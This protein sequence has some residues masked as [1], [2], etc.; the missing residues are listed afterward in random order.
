MTVYRVM[1]PLKE[2]VWKSIMISA[3][4]KTEKKDIV[5]DFLHNKKGT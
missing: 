3:I 1:T 5:M 2:F 4:L